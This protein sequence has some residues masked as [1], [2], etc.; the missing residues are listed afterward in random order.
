MRSDYL[1]SFDQT[2]I[3]YNYSEVIDAKGLVILVPGLSEHS[4][5][6]AHIAKY[7]N[8][9]NYSTITFDNRGNGKSGGPKGDLK[10]YNDYLDDL[11]AIK[12][13]ASKFHKGIFL[14]G[15]SL[16][17]FIVNAYACKYGDIKGVISSGA[18]GV[19]LTK[20]T[21]FRFLP[22]RPL[23]GLNIKNGLSTVLSHDENI[24]IA[25][26]KDPFVNK[27][28]KLRLMGNCFIKG[29]RYLRKNIKN[30]NLPI[31]YLHGGDDR[32]VPLKSTKYLYE[33][34]GS[35]DKEIHIFEGMY[36]EI[37]NEV[38]KEIPLSIVVG[39]LD[40]HE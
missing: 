4:G 14:L 2:K 15:H 24:A 34:V 31:L 3:F 23:G 7:L 11:H 16:G 1:V 27:T 9:H 21:I 33:T 13:M 36:H 28:N 12:E 29:V 25:Y 10:N 17:G 18:V 26:N 8:D 22:F 6:Y 20:V 5:R 19:F 30:V 32:I 37:F 38:E 39:W 35:K 40:K